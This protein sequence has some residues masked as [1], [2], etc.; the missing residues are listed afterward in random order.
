VAVINDMLY[1]AF[2]AAA[3]AEDLAGKRVRSLLLVFPASIGIADGV[4]TGR[5]PAQAVL[6]LLPGI[7]LLAVSLISGERIGAGD[8]LCFMTLGFGY[9]AENVAGIMCI[10]FFMAGLYSLAVIIRSGKKGANE[11]FAFFPFIF[12]AFAA[13]RA[14]QAF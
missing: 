14:L 10:S 7:L 8:A 3:A 4:I 13:D 1:L 11:S 12:F 9:G 5:D 2:L 6:A